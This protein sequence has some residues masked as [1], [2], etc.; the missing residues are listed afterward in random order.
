LTKKE[1]EYMKSPLSPPLE[2]ISHWLIESGIQN[3]RSDPK[4]QGGFSAWYEIYKRRY[5]FIYTEIT[6]YALSTLVFLNRIHPDPVFLK[7]AHKAALWAIRNAFHPK[8][9]VKTRYYLV[10]R[11]ETPNY[12][13]N[14]GRMYAFDTAMVG[15]GLMQLYRV[16]PKKIYLDYA[17]EAWDF[18]SLVLSKK[19]GS[20]YPYFDVRTL[21][22]DEDFAK[23][24]DQAG[25]FHAKCAMFFIDLY[26]HEP[27]RAY[28]DAAVK[29][30]DGVVRK[31][32]QS[33]RFITS[34]KDRSTHLHPH[35]YTLEGLL[36]GG[37][38]LG[39]GAYIDSALEGFRWMRH[40]ISDDGSVSSIYDSSG[41]AYHER[42]DIV[43]QALRIGSVLWGLDKIK[44]T[45]MKSLLAKVREHLLL[46]QFT[47][48]GTQEGGFLYGADTDGRMRVHLNA[49]STMFAL[50]ALWA[51]ETFV[52]KGR[53]VCLDCFI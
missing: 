16:S 23:W 38:Y 49:W 11:Y 26:R 37:H 1:T 34:L 13:F 28:R 40:A 42:S 8:G 31:Q 44:G 19:D 50:Q 9:G 46:F 35:C 7:R 6:G 3:N 33:G 41:F 5:P 25:S 29:L 4:V 48:E 21:K 22:R 20:L 18:L 12:T 43:A 14:A 24:S 2:K 36:Y 53:D 47:E 15:Y 52:D 30:L 39:K 10:R 27:K 17:V 45:Q 51:H 32:D